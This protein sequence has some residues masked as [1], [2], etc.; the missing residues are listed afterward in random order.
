[1]NVS[2]AST[3]EIRDLDIDVSASNFRIGRPSV[4]GARLM[5]YPK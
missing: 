5:V 3:I 1:M 4:R 2:A